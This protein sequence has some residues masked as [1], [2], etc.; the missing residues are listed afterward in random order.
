MDQ[1]DIHFDEDEAL[2][3]ENENEGNADE[4]AAMET[5]GGADAAPA[6]QG[7]ISHI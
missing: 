3:Q 1:P 5:E 7:R 6:T 4:P 2:E